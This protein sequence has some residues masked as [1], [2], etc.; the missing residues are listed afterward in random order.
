[1]QVIFVFLVAPLTEA[2]IIACDTIKTE[3]TAIDS[4]LTTVTSEPGFIISARL[5]LLYLFIN[6]FLN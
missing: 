5:L 4:F 1:M 2:E 6:L 3:F